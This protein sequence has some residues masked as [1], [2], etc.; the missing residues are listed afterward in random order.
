ME[1][2]LVH[3]LHQLKVSIILQIKSILEELLDKDNKQIETSSKMHHLHHNFSDQIVTQECM[4]H[5][6]VSESQEVI[7]EWE[8]LNASALLAQ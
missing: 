1:L 5:L 4:S 6:I 2:L 8:H 7:S 3:N